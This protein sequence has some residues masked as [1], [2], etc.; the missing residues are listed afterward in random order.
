MSHKHRHKPSPVYLMTEP[1][2]EVRIPGGCEDC[3]AY[4]A[5]GRYEADLVL[6]HV[7]HD[8]TCPRLNGVT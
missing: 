2:P 1:P 5:L 4:L 3:A 7:F 8:P 6:V